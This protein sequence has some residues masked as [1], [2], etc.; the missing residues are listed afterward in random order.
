MPGDDSNTDAITT[1][2]V[3]RPRVGSRTPLSIASAIGLAVAGVVLTGYAV[4]HRHPDNWIGDFTSPQ[5]DRYLVIAAVAVPLLAAAIAITAVVVW[6]RRSA[7][8]DLAG[9]VFGL[10][11]LASLGVG[12]LWLTPMGSTADK[13][14]DGPLLPPVVMWIR[15]SDGLLMAAW[16]VLLIGAVR[17]TT[18]PRERRVRGAAVFVAL[19]SIVAISVVGAGYAGGKGLVGRS[20]HQPKAA[21]V[22]VPPLPTTVGT[23]IAYTIPARSAGDVLEAGP[24][25][26]VRGADGLVAYDGSTGARRWSIE[27][28]DLG[29][30]CG[31]ELLRR[32]SRT[33]GVASPRA[34]ASVRTTGI[35]R[36]ATVVVTC[37]RWIVGVDAMTG[38]VRWVNSEGWDVY[39][40]TPDVIAVTKD[41]RSSQHAAVAAMDPR[42]GKVRWVMGASDCTDAESLMVVER[43]IVQEDRCSVSGRWLRMLDV[44]SGIERYIAM[45]E[46]AVRSQEWPR[47]VIR[48]LARSG[49]VLAIE[50]SMGGTDYRTWD[51]GIVAV[52]TRSRGVREVVPHSTKSEYWLVDRYGSEWPPS[53]AITPLASTSDQVMF[54]RLPAGRVEHH[55]AR[56]VFSSDVRAEQWW[57]LVGD[58][59]VTALGRP[60]SGAIVTISP[61]GR[62]VSRPG[63]CGRDEGGVMTVPGGL[64][65][66]CMRT[67]AHSY[68]VTSVDVVGLR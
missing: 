26:V 59:A 31:G 33:L 54:L 22:P 14:F 51:T 46:W 20:I 39:D 10:L 17:P 47:R 8:L 64:L 9:P 2:S 25:F 29:S 36:D 13:E 35:G 7:D 24:G 66:L 18:I 68:K 3:D 43:V 52:D 67:D 65:V 37:S 55:S 45:P 4:A 6:R 5:T 63:P 28:S 57:T 23:R 1:T 16:F 34:E 50:V 48:A 12:W 53:G 61:D 42:T 58:T 32:M 27:S 38:S 21:S 40:A 11:L 30:L 62:V 60:E 56:E 44:H 19:T 15:V 41:D 49:S